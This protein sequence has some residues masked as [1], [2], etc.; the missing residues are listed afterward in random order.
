MAVM[1]HILFTHTWL[2]LVIATVTKYTYLV[3][4][5]PLR[6]LTC[7][8]EHPY[9]AHNIIIGVFLFKCPP[10][11]HGKHAILTHNWFIISHYMTQSKHI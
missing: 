7:S 1:N 4:R 11:S 5:T 6:E 8:A 2:V 9:L 3:Q 10:P